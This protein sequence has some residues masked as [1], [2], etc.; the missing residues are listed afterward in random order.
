MEGIAR[1]MLRDD[2]SLAR[3][4]A[5]AKRDTSL[6]NHPEA[7][8]AWFYQRSRYAETRVGEYPVVRFSSRAP[9]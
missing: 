1:D 7:V 6:S 8:L 2:P 5:E 3:Q 9:E 4:F